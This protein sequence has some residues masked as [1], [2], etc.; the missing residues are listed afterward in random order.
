[1]PQTISYEHKNLQVTFQP[2]IGLD[3]AARQSVVEILNHL[4]ADEAV[5]SLKTRRANGHSSGENVPELQPLYNAQYKQ[6]NAITREIGERIQILGGSPL[7]GPKELL[8][9]AR[10]DGKLTMVPGSIN[11]LADQEAFIRCLRDDIRKCSEEYEDEGTF[12]LLVGVMR[13]HERMAWLLRSHIKPEIIH[14]VGQR[15]NFAR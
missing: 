14:G 2:N 12:E 11:I 4:L 6:I 10:L 9:T 3:A 1:M 13:L 8:D 15:Q 7:S 5:L